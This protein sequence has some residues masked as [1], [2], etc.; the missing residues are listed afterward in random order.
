M[1]V[2]ISAAITTAYANARKLVRLPDGTIYCVYA[3]T[4]AARW[5]IYVKK[6]VDDGATWTDETRISTYAGMDLYHQSV[7][8]IAADSSGNL[9]VVWQ[10]YA[11]GFTTKFQVWYNKFNGSSWSGVVRLS[12]AANM[13]GSH[14]R[15]PSI[16]ADGSANLHVVWDG[17]ATGFANSQIWYSKYTASWS[18][19]VRISDYAGMESYEQSKAAI[20][21]DSLGYL[22]VTWW[23]KAT[24]FTTDN[25]V[26]Y[27]KYTASW[28]APLRIS[29]YALMQNYSQGGISIAIDSNNYVH[30]VWY[31]AVTA[32]ASRIWYTKYTTSWSAPLKISTLAG[33][34]T[35]NQQFP[36]VAIDAS[37]NVHVVW[38]GKSDAYPTFWT[39]FYAKY[40]GSWAVEYLQSA[41]VDLINPNCRWSL[42]PAGNIPFA[43]MSYTFHDPTYVYYDAKDFPTPP[44][45]MIGLNPAFMEVLGL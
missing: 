1:A 10:G 39:I 20:A 22:H 43:G 18:A 16:S 8:A 21:I 29:T 45:R 2:L 40:T 36:T 34:D 42:I 37:D 5:Q 32:G 28:S 13:A 12:D 17:G 24:G 23:G 9:H 33:M 11:T 31:G 38:Y 25:Q 4:E 35:F 41:G 26:W 14:Q 19:P 30:V 27:S 15:Y 6:S 7:P 44:K 3:R